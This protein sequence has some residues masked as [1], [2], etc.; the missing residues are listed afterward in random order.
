[1]TDDQTISLAIGRI[2][3][4]AARPEQD[5]DVAEYVRCRSI[6]LDLIEARP[7]YRPY[8]A[9]HDYARDR[10]NGAQGG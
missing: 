9:A 10:L 5:G 2:F 1:M 3:R 8:V 6:I 4:M 7:D